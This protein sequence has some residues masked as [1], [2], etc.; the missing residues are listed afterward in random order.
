[1]NARF[2]GKCGNQLNEGSKYCRFCGWRVVDDEEEG[3]ASQQQSMETQM[4]MQQQNEKK[5]KKLIIIIAS[6]LVLVG[7][8]ITVY[9]LFFSKDK[10]EPGAKSGPGYT[11]SSES[12]EPEDDNR[13]VKDATVDM[14]YGE[15]EGTVT[16]DTIDNIQEVIDSLKGTPGE[17]PPEQ[18]EAFISKME[19]MVGKESQ[20][21][22][23]MEASNW[24]MM[25][26]FSEEMTL[27]MGPRDFKDAEGNPQ[28]FT[29]EEGCF[30]FE[31]ME[32]DE[33]FNGT[34]LANMDGYVYGENE[35]LMI[36]G[37][38]KM[39]MDYGG[40]GEPMILTFHYNFTSSLTPGGS[41]GQPVE[42]GTDPTVTPTA[43]PT[44]P[45]PSE[46]APIET[47][48]PAPPQ[49]S[50]P[51][52]NTGTESNLSG[53]YTGNWWDNNTQTS[54]K[55]G[56]FIQQNGNNMDLIIYDLNDNT[57]S[58]LESENNIGNYDP[59]T[60]SFYVKD[61]GQYGNY[62]I[63]IMFY[64]TEDGRTVGEGWFVHGD[65]TS[66]KFYLEKQ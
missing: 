7:A 17:V 56:A 64:Q 33:E 10:E 19:N 3:F 61:V 40:G 65:S 11:D 66:V 2:C 47:P 63:G 18:V 29:L 49:T 41:A 43:D 53:T 58:Y 39:S 24:K 31:A 23:S 50:E 27:D 4:G 12:P 54:T 57:Y 55:I 16:M 6:A 42:P 1:M 48:I 46:P 28:M 52:P 37:E 5:S 60:G 14:L 8:G 15:W 38:V 26:A 34:M 25:F 35:K 9:L 22:L 32:K 44:I 59:T 51:A 62:E 21:T 20:A 30:H 45:L 13:I 36:Y